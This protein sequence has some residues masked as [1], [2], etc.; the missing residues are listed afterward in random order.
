MQAECKMSLSDRS[1]YDKYGCRGAFMVCNSP[2]MSLSDRSSLT[3]L[4]G[5]VWHIPPPPRARE[6]LSPILTCIPPR[7]LVCPPPLAQVQ[8]DTLHQLRLRPD[9]VRLLSSFNR[10]N[11]SYR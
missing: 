6:S 3:L 10:P 11:L 1:S 9:C 5:V 7:L 8:E 4:G 2:I